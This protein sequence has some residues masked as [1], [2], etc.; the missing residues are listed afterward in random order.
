MPY[1]K[2][3]CIEILHELDSEEK[4]QLWVWL[5]KFDEDNFFRPP[6]FCLSRLSSYDNGFL[7]VI[8]LHPLVMVV[9]ESPVVQLT[10]EIPPYPNSIDFVAANHLF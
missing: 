8:S 3:K 1:N 9:R 2:M 10:I 4:A 5:A 7:L 6:P